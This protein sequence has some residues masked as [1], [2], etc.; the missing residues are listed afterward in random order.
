MKVLRSSLGSCLK[1]RRRLQRVYFA[2]QTPQLL[3]L[4][5]WGNGRIILKIS[6]IRLTLPKNHP[7]ILNE[8]T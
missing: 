2:T 7:F 3:R 6:S 8:E 4:Q 1:L 5:I